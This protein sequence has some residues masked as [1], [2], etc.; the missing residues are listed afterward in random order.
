MR[1]GAS[2]TDSTNPIGCAPCARGGG[3]ALSATPP[4]T[5]QEEEWRR[6]SL[7]ALPRDVEL[8]LDVPQLE[9]HLPAGAAEA[10]VILTDLR[11][12]VREHPELV[13]RLLGQQDGPAS[14]A[15]FWALAQAAWT[16]GLFCYVPRG[17]I[18]D[19]TLVARQA[20][21]RC[22]RRLPS[23]LARGGRGGLQRDAAGGDRLPGR[24][25]G[26]VR[27]DRRGS[28]RAVLPCALRQPA[29]SR[30]RC[31]AR[32]RRARRGRPGRGGHD[33]QRRG[34]LAGHEARASR[35]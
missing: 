6:T 3:S 33:A 21:P 20:V 24:R 4:P 7:D 15:H 18:V 8:L 29:A 17:V 31:L 14:H 22:R 28:R 10:G 25:R 27:R 12:A 1:S 30:R 16:G 34:R 26:V 23:R 32:R 13:R 19:G 5:G 11:T 9:T 35:C 2:A